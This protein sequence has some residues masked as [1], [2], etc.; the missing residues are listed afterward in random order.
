MAA[1]RSLCVIADDYGIGPETSRGILELAG[2]GRLSGTV[3]LVN[4]PYTEEAV[5][6]WRQAGLPLDLGWHPCLTMDPPIA[7]VEQVPS[8][9]G[10][11]GNLWPLGRF[12]ARLGVGLVRTAE[13]ELELRAQYQRF[14]ELVGHPP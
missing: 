7:P 2:R 4:S 9:V 13:I 3:L 12:L 11:D 6:A 8:L 1:T 14:L 5:R 10:P